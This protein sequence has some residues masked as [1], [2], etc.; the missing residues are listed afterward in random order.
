MAEPIAT[1][2]LPDQASTEGLAAR[3][4][5]L[6][7]VGDAIALWG[8]LGAGKSTFARAL[9]RTLAGDEALEV[10]SPTFTLI[11]IYPTPRVVVAHVDLY[12]LSDIG[13]IEETGFLDNLVDGAIVVE[14]PERAEGLLPTNRLDIALDISGTGRRARIAGSQEWAE[15]LARLA[16]PPVC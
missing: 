15:R 9:I 6:I 3:L 8:E 12:R 4:A 5:P 16:S 11:Q 14:W 1:I 13:E 7:G 10:P 2:D